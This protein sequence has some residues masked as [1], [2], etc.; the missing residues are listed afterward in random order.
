MLHF[1]ENNKLETRKRRYYH[2]MKSDP[3]LIHARE[4]GVAAIYRRHCIFPLQK[5]YFRNCT[6]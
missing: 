3:S 2:M 5:N 6:F 4:N 1:I